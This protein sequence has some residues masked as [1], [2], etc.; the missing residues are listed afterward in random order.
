MSQF[1]NIV[2]SPEYQKAALSTTLRFF[3]IY[4]IIKW[5]FVGF[6]SS[7]FM[8]EIQAYPAQFLLMSVGVSVA[9]GVIV[10]YIKMKREK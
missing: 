10:A 6:D 8:A 1:K 5:A 7:E 2:T 9:Y 3:L 4:L